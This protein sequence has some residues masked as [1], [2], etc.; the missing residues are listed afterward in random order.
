MEKLKGKIVRIFSQRGNWSCIRFEE[1]KHKES[2][3]AKGIIG[4]AICDGIEIAIE[5]DFID[6]PKYGRQFNIVEG[7]VLESATVTFLYR[8]VKGVGQSLAARIVDTLGEDCVDKIKANPAILYKV[9]GIKEKKYN[10]IMESLNENKFIQLY[11]EIFTYFNNDITYAQADKIVEVCLKEKSGFKK[12]RKNPYWLISHVDGFGFKRVDKLALACGIGEFSLERIAAA[13]VYILKDMSVKD[14]H[15]YLKIDELTKSVVDL[16]LPQPTSVSKKDFNF[17]QG[18]LIS[19]DDF[20]DEYI[21]KHKYIKELQD[22]AE[23]FDKILNL[24]SEALI[25]NVEDEIVV[26]EDDRIYTK[27]LYNTEMQL[28][29]SIITMSQKSPVRKFELEYIE[30]VIKEFEENEGIKYSEEQKSAVVTSLLNRVSIISGGPGRGKTTILK[31][32][33]ECWDDDDSVVLLAPTGKAAK[34]MSEAAEHSAKTLQRYKAQ[35]TSAKKE[36]PK[37]ALVI[38]DEAS[39]AGI[40]L[41][42]ALFW[43]AE[44]CNLII[45]G[46]VDQLESIEPGTFLNDIIECGT[47]PTTMLTHGYRNDGSIAYNTRLINAGKSPSYFIYDDEFHFVSAEKQ[48]IVDK[49]VEIYKE[50]L[51]K[52]APCDIGVITPIKKQGYGSVNSLN[53]AIRDIYNPATET[54]PNNKSGFRIYDR[55]MN[56]GNNYKRIII[57][58]FGNE[59]FGVFNGDSGSVDDIDLEAETL[60]VAFDDGR[61]ATYKFSELNDSLILSY[62]MTVHKSQGS[63]WKSLI[64]IAS[65]EHSYFY[66]RKL[67]YTAGTRAKMEEYMIG[68]KKTAAMAAK[69]IDS[70]KRNSHLKDRIQV[71]K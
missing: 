66:H 20:A 45:I 23:A 61:K 36:R 54:N 22:Y 21:S 59:A 8:C 35:L 6:D 1:S 48:E 10:M 5:G 13:I 24:M 69:K 67:L 31:I 26:I 4:G 38:F 62:A 32:I 15:C 28:A 25:A 11:I 64:V 34:K 71:F 29:K 50:L 52:Y 9:K 42:R 63:E 37:K 41:A 49:T 27:N 53:N 33:L 12:V 18:L 47:V 57:D 19:A 44:D 60:D 51:K 3:V 14:G 17:I 39:M 68:S 40:E 46:D 43:I 55:V 65:S 7:T 58:E 2:F 30:E 56:V 70:S 16:L